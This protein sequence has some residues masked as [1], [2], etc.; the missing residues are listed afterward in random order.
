VLRAPEI[1]ELPRVDFAEA[2]LIASAERSGV[3]VVASSE[4]SI[5]GVIAVARIE[6]PVVPPTSRRPSADLC[7]GLPK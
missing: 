4:R 2:C 7:P 5:D 3:G 6:P 1:Y